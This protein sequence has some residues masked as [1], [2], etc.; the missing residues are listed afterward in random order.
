MQN[1]DFLNDNLIFIFCDSLNSLEISG[2]IIKFF[3][4]SSDVNFAKT[5]F[6]E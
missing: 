4:V 5:L 3:K 2:N 6:T 1:A